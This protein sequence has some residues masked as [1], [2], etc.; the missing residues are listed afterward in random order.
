MAKS[1]FE[2]YFLK[3]KKVVSKGNSIKDFQQIMQSKNNVFSFSFHLYDTW[4]Y[5]L[6]KDIFNNI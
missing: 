2:K 5:F 1:I 4:K 6:R 3:G